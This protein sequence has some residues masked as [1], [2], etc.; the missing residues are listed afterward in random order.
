MH[1]SQR[2]LIAFASEQLSGDEHAGVLLHVAQC[3]SCRE[4]L[5]L[6]FPD[7]GPP[8]IQVVRPGKKDAA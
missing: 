4:L 7:E 6:I 1:P 2:T 5:A 8:P 3:G